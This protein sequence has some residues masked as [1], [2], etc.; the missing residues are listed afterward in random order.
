MW[1]GLSSLHR[2][3]S[4]IPGLCSPDAS[5]TPIHTTQDN[6][7]VS[8]L[9]Q[10]PLGHKTS[11]WGT[12]VLES[13][14]NFQSLHLIPHLTCNHQ[15]IVPH[16]NIAFNGSPLSTTKIHTVGPAFEASHH[17]PALAVT[18]SRADSLLQQDTGGG[19]LSQT[20]KGRGSRGVHFAVGV[21]AWLEVTQFAQMA[22]CK[23]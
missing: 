15:N 10:M 21:A 9:C 17:L 11:L 22:F 19:C 8:R 7:T 20:R 6:Q 23:M 16:L 4:S 13:G 2:L 3:S 12:I 5:S 18:F 14:H 1:W